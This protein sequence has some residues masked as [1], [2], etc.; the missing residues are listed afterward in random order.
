MS[1]ARTLAPAAVAAGT[2]LVWLGAA[3]VSELDPC[4]DYCQRVGKT[5]G[6]GPAAQYSDE[7]ACLAMCKAIGQ[8]AQKTGA[9]DDTIDC[10]LLSLTDVAERLD[11]GAPAPAACLDV[12]P[13]S[14]RCAGGVCVAWCRLVQSVCTGSNAQYA[15]EADCAQACSAFPPGNLANPAGPAFASTP[16]TNTLA[17]RLYHLEAASVAP[18]NH[19]P[20]LAPLGTSTPCQ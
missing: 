19:C 1:L 14:P 8:N 16:S 11:G 6:T 13:Y 7:G 2:V 12:G 17:C 9:A 18:P 3:C 20:H 10:R 15:S 4:P 5:C